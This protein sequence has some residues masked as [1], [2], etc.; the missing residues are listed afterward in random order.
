MKL[1]VWINII[2]FVAL[3]VL[4]YFSRHQFEEVFAKLDNLWLVP[5]LLLVPLKFFNFYTIAKM[6][7]EYLLVLGEKVSVKE[8]FKISMEMNFVNLVFPSGGASGFSYLSLRLRPLGISTAKTTMV[9]VARFGLVFLTF[10]L[11][12]FFGMLILAIEGKASNLTILVASVISTLTL[13]GAAIFI[14][15]VSSKARITAFT[16]FL[17]RVINRVARAIHRQDRELIKIEKVKRTFTELHEDYSLI[18][19][20]FR[21]L[22]KTAF[23]ALM[24]NVSEI[25]LI[26]TVFVAHGEWINVGALIIAYAVA[27]FAGLVSL[28]GGVGVYE[29]LMTSVMASAG[30]PAALALSATVMYRVINMVVFLPIG[31]WLYRKFLKEPT[32][33]PVTPRGGKRQHGRIDPHTN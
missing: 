5:L 6:Y 21:K 10:L 32:T 24:I 14:F 26:Y 16:A 18:S 2:T 4:V 19:R 12:I 29:F 23:W 27:N 9:Q 13:V 31:Y 30:V 20:D 22:K 11:L 25:V 3:V 15:I 17:P 8:L 28:F 7:Q 1:K 33:P